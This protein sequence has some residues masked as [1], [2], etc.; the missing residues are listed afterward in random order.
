MW[1]LFSQFSQCSHRYEQKHYSN[2]RTFT[3]TISHEGFAITKK[4]AWMSLKC[5]LTTPSLHLKYTWICRNCTGLP[6]WENLTNAQCV[7]PISNYSLQCPRTGDTPDDGAWGSTAFRHDCLQTR[8]VLTAPIPKLTVVCACVRASP[9]TPL[10]VVVVKTPNNKLN[11]STMQ[12][13]YYSA[14]WCFTVIS[15]TPWLTGHHE[16]RL[17]NS[18]RI[19]MSRTVDDTPCLLTAS[20]LSFTNTSE[21]LTLRD[22]KKIHAVNGGAWGNSNFR[23]GRII[24][25]SSY[26][27]S[28]RRCSA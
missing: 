10:F 6:T 19:K 16:T 20:C 5:N 3:Q 7:T 18:M 26:H 2:I 23:K 22:K 8:H 27:H 9:P 4:W 25:T 21:C 12:A 17:C 15:V 28:I 24:N 11:V 14:V 13:L 1:I